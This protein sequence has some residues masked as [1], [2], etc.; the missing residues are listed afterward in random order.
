MVPALFHF[1]NFPV[2]LD[3]LATPARCTVFSLK[4]D[5]QFPSDLNFNSAGRVLFD[6]G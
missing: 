1:R 4:E 6:H 3:R 5:Q 2:S